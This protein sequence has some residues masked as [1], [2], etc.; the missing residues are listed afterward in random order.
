MAPPSSLPLTPDYVRLGSRF[1]I[2]SWPRLLLLALLLFT[3]RLAS[4][5][6]PG[7]APTFDG[8]GS[9]LAMREGT[10]AVLRRAAYAVAGRLGAAS[11][12]RRAL[13]GLM[14]SWCAAEPPPP[15]TAYGASPP[16][17]SA[18]AL[19][20][21]GWAA[22]EGG[23][24]DWAART[25]TELPFRVC[26]FPRDKDTQVSAY[27]HKEG[28]WSG[29]KKGLVQEMLPVL[30]GA[31]AWNSAGGRTLVLDVRVVGAPSPPTHTLFCPP[32]Q[33]LTH[34]AS[35]LCFS[36]HPAPLLTPLR[37]APTSGSTRCSP[38]RAGTT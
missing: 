6:A 38:P 35:A 8:P 26:T 13:T 32:P 31:D 18:A 20:A 25:T 12:R 14:R 5:P 21:P 36:P 4:S 19:G 17:W 24:C 16:Q 34:A 10:G 27:I 3:L 29:W 7:V 11:S 15:A 28:H 2:V 37:L 9:L 1:C 22:E 23:V 30:N 33:A